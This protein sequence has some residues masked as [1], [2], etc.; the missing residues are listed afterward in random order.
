MQ[1]LPIFPCRL[2]QSI[3]GASELNFCVRDGNRWDLTAIVTAM[4]YILG[5]ISVYIF[6]SS[7]VSRQ[8]HNCIEFIRLSL[9]SFRIFSFYLI[10]EIKP[11]TY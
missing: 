11:S 3:F 6:F 9:S 8:I 2:R 7:A 4:V 1:Q 5:V 10:S